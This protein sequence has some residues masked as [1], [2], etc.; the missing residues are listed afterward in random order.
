MSMQAHRYVLGLL[1]GIA[2]LGLSLAS[3]DVA[4][5]SADAASIARGAYLARIG[6]C[7]GCHTD[8]DAVAMAGG[9]A[10]P[11]PFGTIYAPNVTPDA[12]T[13]IGQFKDDDF[14]HA[15]HDGVRRDGALLY[16]AF[17]FVA[18]TKLRRA[19]VDDI[20]AYL[21]S[22]PAVQRTPRANSLRFPYSVRGVLRAW[23]ALFFTAGEYHDDPQHDAQWNR[24][25][26][27]VQGLGHCQSC[28]TQR[29]FLGAIDADRVL[30]GGLIPVQN[31]VAPNLVG[32]HG[33]QQ[34]QRSELAKFLTTGVSA[35]RSAYGPMAEVIHNSL[36]YLTVA[37]TKA[38]VTYLTS[39][40]TQTTAAPPAVIEPPPQQIENLRSEGQALYKKYCRGCH[41]DDGRGVDA[42]YPA[43]A[44]NASVTAARAINPI[45]MVLLGGFAPPTAAN[46]RP[47]SMPAFSH[48]LSDREVAAIITYIRSAWSNDAAAVSPQTIH[49]YRSTPLQ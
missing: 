30:A 36:Q 6:D 24:G 35:R 21:Q 1:V 9:R 25:A 8:R 26:Y 49:R 38:M 7:A 46:P 41:Q 5:A 23:R 32:K 11:T 13:G 43:L 33:P 18:Y 39:L 17:P 31:W 2:A 3:I 4:A 20:F 29:N 45:R 10:I 19:D 42:I 15:L 47:Y 40:P 48:K 12:T 14:W 28:H 37:D 34:W 27:L 22:L 16:P 44:D